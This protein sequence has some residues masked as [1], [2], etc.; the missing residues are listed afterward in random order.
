[1]ILATSGLAGPVKGLVGLDLPPIAMGV[2]VLATPPV[3]AAALLA[4]MKRA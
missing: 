1:M 4:M 3:E 2:L